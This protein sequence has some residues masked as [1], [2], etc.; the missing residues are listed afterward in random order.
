MC[1]MKCSIDECTEWARVRGWCG[2]HY[3]RWRRFGD[4]EFYPPPAQKQCTIDGCGGV[5]NARGLC[6]KH[7]YRWWRYGD[8]LFSKNS[9]RVREPIRSYPDRPCATCGKYFSPGASGA[10]KYCS[11]PCRKNGRSS[12]GINRRATVERL[13]KAHGWTCVLCGEPVDRNLY[14]PA[15]WAGSVEHVIPVRHGGTDD[16]NNLALAHLRCN[17]SSRKD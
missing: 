11:K 7:Y 4:P 8:P 10:R 2:A 12:S 15:P 1:R 14:W 13:G 6:G 5:T 3:Q 9:P 16:W 17:V